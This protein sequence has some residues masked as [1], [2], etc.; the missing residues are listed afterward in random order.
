M[1]NF[2]SLRLCFNNRSKP[3][4]S[5]FTSYSVTL[6]VDNVNA[7]EIEP[8]KSRAALSASVSKLISILG[9]ITSEAGL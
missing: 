6:Q 9:F 7:E 4:R 2:L 5:L 1:H 3:G 8:V